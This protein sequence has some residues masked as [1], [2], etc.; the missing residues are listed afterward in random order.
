[1]ID[2][3]GKVVTEASETG[4]VYRKRFS[5]S[6]V[7]IPIGAKLKFTRDKTKICTVVSDNEVEYED[8]RYSLSRLAHKFI[9][10]LGYDWKSIQGPKFFEYNDK[11]LNEL[12]K[13]II[14]DDTEE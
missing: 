12:R 11:T 14:A 4:I 10:E 5:F 9:T 13:E 8:Q 6:S 2:S 7:G 3:E 1:M